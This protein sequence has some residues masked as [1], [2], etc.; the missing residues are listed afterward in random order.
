MLG[1]HTKMSQRVDVTFIGPSELLNTF[2]FAA[3]TRA[4]EKTVTWL[5]RKT[6]S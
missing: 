5:K 6:K 2:L 4:V 1:S 3:G